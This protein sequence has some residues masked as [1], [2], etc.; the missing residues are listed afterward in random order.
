MDLPVSS[1]PVESK[2]GAPERTRTGTSTRGV[3]AKKIFTMVSN[4]KKVISNFIIL[5]HFLLMHI[6]IYI[7]SFSQALNLLVFSVVEEE[8]E[9]KEIE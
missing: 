5:P 2:P 6:Y 7:A 3:E 9:D 1:S 4:N 8:V